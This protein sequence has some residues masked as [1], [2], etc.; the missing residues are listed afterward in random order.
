MPVF[1]R[2]IAASR[3]AIGDVAA[4]AQPAAAVRASAAPG[5]VFVELGAAVQKAN[6]ARDGVQI[7]V[8]KFDPAALGDALGQT[9]LVPAKV[10]S[11]GIQPGVTVAKGTTVDL[12]LTEPTKIKVSVLQKAFS[13]MADQTLADVFKNVIRDNAQVQSVLARNDNAA[14]L[15]TDDQAALT[16]ALQ[17]AGH[18]VGTDPGQDITAAFGTLQAAFTFGT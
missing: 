16:S 5:T 17:Q 4:E 12:V 11:Q 7:H 6:V 9:Q 14:T 15:S 3:A 8:V 1:N 2:G 10:V 13:P 18:P